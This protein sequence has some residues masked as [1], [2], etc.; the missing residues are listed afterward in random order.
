MLSPLASIAIQS[1]DPN[2]KMPDSDRNK[3][4]FQKR[5]FIGGV[6][7]D[8][9]GDVLEVRRPSD[10]M[11]C[12]EVPIAAA[13]IVDRAVLDVDGPYAADCLRFFAECA[14]E[15]LGGDAAATR[16]AP[17]GSG[18]RRALR[19]RSD[20]ALWNFPVTQAVT[21]IGPALAAGND[22]SN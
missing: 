21:D 17:T 6:L 19:R 11:V 14:D 8:G 22:F 15:L 10:G 7:V 9:E 4:S 5:H 18:G 12:A 2:L 1:L 20:F 16:S 3:I 13:A